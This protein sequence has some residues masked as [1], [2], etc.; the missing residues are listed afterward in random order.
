MKTGGHERWLDILSSRERIALVGESWYEV[1]DVFPDA[2]AD[3]IKKAYRELS[4]LHHPD[5]NPDQDDSI[6]KKV[7]AAYEEAMSSGLDAAAR[8]KIAALRTK[9][10]KWTAGAR[11]STFI[12]KID[13]DE[14]MEMLLDDSCIV[15]NVSEEEGMLRD[16]DELITFES[17]NYL[18]LRLKPEAFQE[19]LDN[20]REDENRVVTVSWSG[21]RCGEFCTLL[22]D[23][24]GFDADQL[25]QLHGGIQAWEEWT[26]NPKNAKWVKKLRQHLRPSGN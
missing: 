9:V 26:R 15:L 24:F 12:T 10:K 23:I 11:S 18:K 20:L 19:R 25:C 21:G 22:V 16:A 7:Q 4:L 1:L 13:P 14:L 8:A 2:E 3:A 5:K 17:L 6:F